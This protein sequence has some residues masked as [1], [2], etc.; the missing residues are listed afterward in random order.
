MKPKDWLTKLVPAAALLVLLF[1]F[2]REMTDGVRQGLTLCGTAVIPSLFPFLVFCTFF[3]RS[4]L[5]ATVGEKLSR[6]TRKLLHLPPAASGAVLLGLCGG[7]PVGARM[8][9]QLLEEGS[10]T[11]S[12]AQRMCLFCVAA[13]PAF[14]TG[15]VGA[16]MLGSREAGWLL[17]GALTLANLTVGVLLRFTDAE[18]QTVPPTIPRQPFARCF[19]EAVADAGGSMLSVC[20]WVLL[21]SG[22]CAVLEKLPSSVSTPFICV[23]EVTNGCRTGAENGL[24]LPVLAAIL[25]FGGLSVHCQILSDVTA[26]G[27]KLSRFWAFRVV[28]GALA[29]VYCTGLAQ[30][31]PQAQTVALLRSDVPIHAVSA[32]VPT[33]AALLATVAVFILNTAKEP[34]DRL[35]SH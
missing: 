25:G 29:A 6:P 34:T 33:S 2:P 7:Y 32:S 12:Q 10:V 14:V 18:P 24:S 35:R 1:R 28:C 16:S 21:F 23:L 4:G 5:C 13:G 22:V 26:C 31:F 17:F 9:A 20:A 11:R 3:V 27:T 30:L 15:T 8:T 19:C